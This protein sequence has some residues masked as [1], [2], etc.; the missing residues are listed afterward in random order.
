MTTTT[1]QVL[2]VPTPAM[3][4]GARVAAS[5]FVRAA[6][7]LSAAFAAA[8]IS[9]SQEAAQVR[10]L[11]YEVRS[12]DPRFAADLYAAADRHELLD[13]QATPTR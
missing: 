6:R 4:R 5:L 8:P 3:P 13:D 10:A 11:A 2:S 7:G 9:R 12:A 1:V